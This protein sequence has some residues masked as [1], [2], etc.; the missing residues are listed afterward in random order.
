[1]DGFGAVW[2]IIH[3]PPL[4]H[5][6]NG[7]T[8]VRFAAHFLQLVIKNEKRMSLEMTWILVGPHLCDFDHLT[9]L[10]PV[11]MHLIYSIIYLP[12]YLSTI[13]HLFSQDFLSIAINQHCRWEYSDEQN[14]V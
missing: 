2:F 14:S 8:R 3:L 1:M 10:R 5:I 7:R 4:E 12:T 9:F 13:F 11:A 6:L